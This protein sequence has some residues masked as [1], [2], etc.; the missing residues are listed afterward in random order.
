MK[1][2]IQFPL[3]AMSPGLPVT[4]CRNLKTRGNALVIADPEA[5]NEP[6]VHQKALETLLANRPGPMTP[7]DIF[8]RVIPSGTA[9][10]SIPA[11]TLPDTDFTPGATSLS[12]KGLASLTTSLLD[13]YTRLDAR[14]KAAGCRFQPTIGRIHLMDSAGNSI[15]TSPPQL[16]ECGGW[17]CASSITLTCSKENTSLKTPATTVTVSTFRIEAVIASLGS[18]AGLT[19]SATVTLTPQVHPINFSAKAAYRLT[20]TDTS[21]PIL[22]A[23]FPGCT[24]SFSDLSASRAADLRALIP[25][26]AAVERPAGS[27]APAA[28]SSQIENQQSPSPHLEKSAIDSALKTAVKPD[29]SLSA[30]I[31]REITAPAGFRGETVTA[32]GDSVAWADITVLQAPP[33]LPRHHADTPSDSS[34]WTG[35]LQLTFADGSTA[36][37]AIGSPMPMPSALPAL[38]CL[39]HSNARRIEL[40]IRNTAD[41]SIRYATAILSPTADG[42]SALALDATLKPVAFSLWSGSYP[43]TPST[44]TAGTK[45]YPGVIVTASMLHPYTALGAHYLTDHPVVALHPAVKS[46]SSWDFTR[47]HLYAFSPAGIFTVA[48]SSAKTNPASALIDPRGVSAGERTAYT[49]TGVMALTDS[50]H[51]ITLRGARTYPLLENV[52][53]SAIEWVLPAD[54]LRMHTPGCV[55]ALDLASMQ[56]HTLTHADSPALIPVGWTSRL[57]LTAPRRVRFLRLA[58]AASSFRGVIRLLGDSGAGP[59]AARPLLTLDIDGAVNAPVAARVIAH[60]CSF[61]TLSITGFASPDMTIT[62]ASLITT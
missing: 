50:R 27:I 61:L 60:P 21:S 25:R 53:A 4:Q 40:W 15:Y 58:M 23:A 8:L 24:D 59:D 9:S 32:S 54:Q 28:G 52:T 55:T 11:T 22:T 30:S 35:T 2:T 45:R 31:L 44:S 16:L 51:L 17:Q 19:A 56:T 3:T 42:R 47:C 38:I 36:L 57:P 14:V 18:Y 43:D 37:R 33:A 29:T 46:A 48:F 49:T 13:T 6:T 41:S 5:K 62:S 7:P 26:L 1:N 12:P 20:R 10:E 39:P 34:N